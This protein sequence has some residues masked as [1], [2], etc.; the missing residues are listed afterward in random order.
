MYMALITKWPARWRV[1]AKSS[2]IRLLGNTICAI[3]T[4]FIRPNKAHTPPLLDEAK[5]TQCQFCHKWIHKGTIARHIRHQH[6]PAATHVMCTYCNSQY[7]NEASL[8]NHMRLK[9]NVFS[10]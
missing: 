1:V 2:R 4:E 6:K 10:K 5:M 8:S 9:H 7:K 3:R